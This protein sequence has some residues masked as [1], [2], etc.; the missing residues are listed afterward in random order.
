MA[1]V[2]NLSCAYLNSVLL[3]FN[4][5]L[6]DQSSRFVPCLRSEGLS[7]Q[8]PRAHL[9]RNDAGVLKSV[10]LEVVRASGV[11]LRVTAL[12]IVADE[13]ATFSLP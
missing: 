4:F 9:R 5:V 10:E 6:S 13:C 11:R 8:L 1:S 2:C 12:A 7:F 3:S